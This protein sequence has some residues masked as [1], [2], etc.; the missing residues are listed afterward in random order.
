MAEHRIVITARVTDA[1]KRERRA[2]VPGSQPRNVDVTR[3]TGD[4]G[5]GPA[6]SIAWPRPISNRQPPPIGNLLPSGDLLPIGKPPSVTAVCSAL[7]IASRAGRWSRRRSPYGVP[8]EVPPLRCPPDRNEIA[9][10]ARL[11]YGRT[12]VFSTILGVS[13]PLGPLAGAPFSLAMGGAALRSVGGR[14]RG[15]VGRRGNPAA[16]T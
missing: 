7:R 8:A 4:A 1:A 3:R 13:S 9:L 6:A 10:R 12:S 16:A 11:G 15:G 14:V 2:V 5:R